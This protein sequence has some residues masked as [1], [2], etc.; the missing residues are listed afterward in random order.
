[1]TSLSDL[2]ISK[3]TTGDSFPPAPILTVL[4]IGKSVVVKTVPQ[5][6]SPRLKQRAEIGNLPAA[7]TAEL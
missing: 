7:P 3:W 2:Q 5:L 4:R 1:M 6:Q